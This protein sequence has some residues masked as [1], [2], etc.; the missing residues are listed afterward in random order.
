MIESI[1]LK[2][3]FNL[4]TV[5]CFVLAEIGVGDII[6][7]L[8]KKIQEIK[9]DL[10]QLGESPSEIH[11]MITSTNLLRT[12]EFLSKANEKKTQLLLAYEKYSKALEEL[13]SSVF[14]IQKELKDILRE[15]SLIIL[16]LKKK[17]SKPKVKPKLKPKKSKK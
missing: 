8:R 2:K 14:E 10:E 1:F 12:N 17:S 15:Q 4:F 9:F 3:I 13:L 5:T 11:E 7:E 6:Y 16:T